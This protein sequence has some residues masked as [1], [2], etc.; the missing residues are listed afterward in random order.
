MGRDT[1]GVIGVSLK[2][3]NDFVVEMDVVDD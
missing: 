3:N 2:K 1:T